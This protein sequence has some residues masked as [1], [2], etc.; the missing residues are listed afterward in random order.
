[1]RLL[2]VCTGNICRSPVADAVARA[3]IAA[4]GLDWMADSAGTGSW[5]TG[6]A[7]DP[8]AIETGA[9]RGYDLAGLRARAVEPEDFRRFDHLIALDSGHYRHLRNLQPRGT[10]G[11]VSR[12][13]DWQAGA[14][15]A[16]VPDPYYGDISDFE[17]VLDLVESGVDALIS[18]LQAGHTQPSG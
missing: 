1:M 13:M 4:L 11:R 14:G 6:E 17:Q 18:A 12:L 3:R 5:H 9:R 10:G 2:F 15:T 16:D 7:P 8:R